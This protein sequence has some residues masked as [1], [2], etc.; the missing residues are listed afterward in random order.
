MRD[1]VF[2]ERVLW[3][4]RPR[5]PRP[6]RFARGLSMSLAAMAFVALGYAVVVSVW[7]HASTSKLV[8]SSALLLAAGFLIHE[9]PVF[10][11]RRSR[12]VVTENHVVVHWG[13]LRRSI[14]RGGIS[15]ARILWRED[16]PTVGDL[17]LVRAVRTGALARTLEVVLSD[18]VAPDRVFALIRGV[19]GS[20]AQGNGARSLAQRLDRGE[21]VLWSGVPHKTR[22]NPKRLL[23][24]GGGVACLASLVR[25]G[26]GLRHAW[27]LVS[28]SG[29]L[30]PAGM[31]LV[32]ATGVLGLAVLACVFVFLLYAASI[33]P[34]DRVRRT[35][36]WVTNRRVLIRRG[37]EELS[38][39]RERIALVVEANADRDRDV[40]LVVDGPQARSLGDHGVLAGQHADSLQPV[41]EAVD[42]PETVSALL[43]APQVVPA[44]KEVV[45]SLPPG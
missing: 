35:R 27:S 15:Y 24:L 44:N 45:A 33:R 10:I 31:F 34:R 26:F 19:E 23:L 25:M 21:R 7:L 11:R 3:Q 37:R 13:R 1:S 30:P 17:V 5:D 36:Y 22:W 38:L 41:F 40:Y 18:V 8:S 43:R 4:G 42:D 9:G 6:T 32:R 12:Y 29:V 2:G 39:D 16:D 20:L 28:R 14:E